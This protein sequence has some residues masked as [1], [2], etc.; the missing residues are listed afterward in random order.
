MYLF[1]SLILSLC[2]S[3]I[4]SYLFIETD[5]NNLH[6]I[7]E[8]THER[9]TINLSELIARQIERQQNERKE[10]ERHK[11]Y[12]NS[13]NTELA[14]KPTNNKPDKLINH[15][16]I[17]KIK[18]DNRND[19][20]IKKANELICMKK[21][22]KDK[23]TINSEQNIKI[24]KNSELSDNKSIHALT[25]VH[26][27]TNALTAIHAADNAL[28][29]IHA[30]TNVL[31]NIHIADNALTAIHAADNALTNNPATTN[32]ATNI[33]ATTNHKTDI[34]ATDK[35]NNYAS[36]KKNNS[37]IPI[38]TILSSL[39][40]DPIF[41]DRYLIYPQNNFYPFFIKHENLEIMI[42]I[43]ITSIIIKNIITNQEIIKSSKNIYFKSSMKS[44]IEV[45][46]RCVKSNDVIYK[47]KSKVVSVSKAVEYKD[48]D[49]KNNYNKHID[50][51]KLDV[52]KLDNNNLDNDKLDINNLNNNV[53]LN[54]INND[55]DTQKI[56]KVYLVSIT[57]IEN[58]KINIFHIKFN[59]YVY[60]MII[61]I[62]LY[63]VNNKVDIKYNWNNKLSINYNKRELLVKKF[64][65]DDK[66]IDNEISILN[67]IKHGNASNV[68]MKYEFKNFGIIIY[69]DIELNHSITLEE[70]MI[71]FDEKWFFEKLKFDLLK[72]LIYLYKRNICHNNLSP[73]SIYF[74]DDKFILTNWEDAI[75]IKQMKNKIDKETKSSIYSNHGLHFSNFIGT[76]NF[77]SP[78]I[79]L[80]NLNLSEIN[81]DNLLKSD[82]FSFGILLYL[83]KFGF[84]PYD[85]PN[86]KELIMKESI[87]NNDIL[88]E[89]KI[90]NTIEK[91]IIYDNYSL[92]LKKCHRFFDMIHRMLKNNIDDRLD[93]IDV[94]KHPF[95]WDE[96][97]IF[98]FLATIS[99]YIENKHK[100][101]RQLNLRL[102]MNKK[103]IF[104]SRWSDYLHP[105]IYKDLEGNKSMFFKNLNQSIYKN[106]TQLIDLQNDNSQNYNSNINHSQSD[107]S[108]IN[109]SQSDNSNINKSN[110]NRTIITHSQESQNSYVNNKSYKPYDFQSVRGLLRAIRNKGRHYQELEPSI[111][112]IYG[113]FPKEFINYYMDRFP[114]LVMVVHYSA[115][116]IAHDEIINEFY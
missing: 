50:N 63:I 99:D 73:K 6:I 71:C 96:D 95:Y 48:D 98:Q 109:H 17:Q 90:L 42:I 46:D 3:F 49:R 13:K 86:N 78:E 47:F 58:T 85:I 44:N 97:K 29:N 54:L 1:Y 110:I 93:I 20:S 27:F 41:F 114:T 84:H 77:R 35:K 87:K 53:Y 56:K 22:P 2:N 24:C 61:T 9:K 32:H 68:I 81:F 15:F 69:N 67:K 91:N 10:I 16:E 19:I 101:T 94:K 104:V 62:L 82:V 8:I 72:V 106:N 116:C 115:K 64:N 76:E 74:T 88:L 34:H 45:E 112:K 23:E 113:S 108:N 43:K 79:I 33:N 26:A 7:N 39:F 21:L 103:K 111:K 38:N 59:F 37:L 18:I 70:F 14:L 28:T 5:D 65:Y 75:D 31:T 105:E 60:L 36:D 12:N 4:F 89:T 57:P 25:N 55:I 11:I 30:T 92:K 107:N 66:R 51:D 102:E 40:P 83:V 80:L 100:N 52:H